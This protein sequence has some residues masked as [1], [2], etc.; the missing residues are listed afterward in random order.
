MS[1]LD[2]VRFDERGLVPVIAQA[3]SSGEVLMMA[4]A[5]REA[6]ALTLETGFAHY[7]SRSRGELWKK[8]D[9]SGHLQA[10]V[11]LRLDCDGDAILY[12]VAQT[13]AACHTDAPTC[14]FRSVDGDDELVGSP[15]SAHILAR[16]DETIAIRMREPKAGSYTNYLLDKGLDKI[17]KKVGEEAT[18]VVIAAKNGD[19][20]EIISETG[21]ILF[22][23]LVMLRER[24]VPLESVWEEMERRFGSPPRERSGR[25]D[26]G[27]SA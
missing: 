6:L 25:R 15:N 14:F 5:N 2:E 4:W 26:E 13:G 10:L 3:A 22:H 12:R 1:W 20:A 9:T 18:E 23:M 19:T 17:L 24:G 7:W 27:F 16:V 11:E 21:D 8:G